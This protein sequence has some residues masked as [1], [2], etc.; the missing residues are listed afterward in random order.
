MKKILVLLCFVPLFTFQSKAQ[1]FA[2]VDSEYILENMS[3]YRDAQ[4]IL[5][6]ISLDWQEEIELKFA[7]IDK[8]YKDYQAEAVLLPD[9]I[10]KN[11]RMISSPKKKKPRIF[12]KKDLVKMVIYLKKEKSW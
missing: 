8:M 6:K 1:K 4:D 12:R 10:K 7:A 11:V 9:D 5:D 2:F 3:E